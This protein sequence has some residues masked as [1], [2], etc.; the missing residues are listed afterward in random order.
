MILFRVERGAR[1]TGGQSAVARLVIVE[2]QTDLLQFVLT[3]QPRGCCPHLL[4]GRQQQAEQY[5]HDSEC[6]EKFNE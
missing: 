6:Y 4:D 2:R 5:P 3:T 1:S